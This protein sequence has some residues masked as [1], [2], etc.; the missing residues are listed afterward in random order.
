MPSASTRVDR[1]LKPRA[2]PYLGDPRLGET[3]RHM[4]RH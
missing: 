2:D 4:H 3:R 1:A